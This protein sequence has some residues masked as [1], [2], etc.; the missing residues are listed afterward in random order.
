[1]IRS[2]STLF[3]FSD[4]LEP[5]A[6]PYTGIHRMFWDHTIYLLNPLGFTLLQVRL[7]S[8][9]LFASSTCANMR[10]QPLTVAVATAIA[11]L[12]HVDA[13]WRS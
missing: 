13:F 11:G 1:M 12:G 4:G 8:S 2:C 5:C 6:L 3:R 10:S 7:R 9:V